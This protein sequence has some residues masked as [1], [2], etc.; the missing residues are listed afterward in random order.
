MPGTILSQFGTH[1]IASKQC[2][3]ATVSTESAMSSRE[4][5]EYFMPEWPIAIPSQTAIVLN[6]IATPPASS[7]H[8]LRK[9]PT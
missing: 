2:A 8:F 1:I 4:G 3:R 6:S 9:V 5:S 7:M